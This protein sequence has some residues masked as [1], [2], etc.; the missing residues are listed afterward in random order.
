[1]PAAEQRGATPP[2]A[3]WA[4]TWWAPTVVLKAAAAT[5]REKERSRARKASG[6]W[7][8]CMKDYVKAT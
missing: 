6:E 7:V 1:M 8:Q 2:T 3:R 4:H 5:G